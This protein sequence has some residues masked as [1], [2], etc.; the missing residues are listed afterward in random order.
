LTCK[1]VSEFLMD[2]LDGSLPQAQRAVFDGHVQACPDCQRYIDSYKRAVEMGRAAYASGE[3]GD[4]PEELVR[5]ILNAR[6]SSN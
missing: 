6:S 2:Y 3:Q 4:P 5:S 1:E